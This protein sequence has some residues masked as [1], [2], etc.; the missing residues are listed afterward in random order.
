M[1]RVI[2]ISAS[3]IAVLLLSLA[4]GAALLFNT[5]P[6]RRFIVAQAEPRIS[7]AIGSDVTI[8]ALE[9]AP[10]SRLVLRNVQL[11]DPEG[12]WLT[13]ETVGLA[14]RPFRLIGGDIDVRRLNISGVKL[15]RQPLA[16]ETKQEE[17]EPVDLR[18]PDDLPHLTIGEITLDDFRSGLGGETVRL[19]GAGRLAMGDSMV[20][21]RLNLTSEND[22]DTVDIA[23]ELSP[24]AERLFVDATLAA[25]AGGVIDSFANLNGPLFINA[26]GDSPTDNAL[27]NINA[28]VADYGALE[29]T[30]SGD[31]A[32]INDIGLSALFTP[33]SALSGIDELSKPITIGTAFTQS[34]NNAILTLTDS[35]S[36][37][38][39]I[40][41]TIEWVNRRQSLTEIATDID[42]TFDGD[43]R[44]NI[45]D[46]SGSSLDAKISLRQLRDDYAFTASIA[47][48]GVEMMVSDGTTNLENL[49]TGVLQ[50][51]LTP[52]DGIA[53]LPYTTQVESRFRVD[54][55][56]AVEL[57][58]VSITLADGSSIGADAS[59]SF[60][61]ETV[62][63]T[64]DLEA[65]PSL[66]QSFVSSVEPANSIRA[67]FEASGPI[68][69]FAANAT[70]NTPAMAIS[71]GEAP[72]L[73]IKAAFAGLP[74]LPTGDL[75]A[76]AVDG[77]GQFDLSLRATNDG[78]I[79]IPSLQYTGAGFRLAGSGLVNLQTETVEI[80]ADYAGENDA[81]P[82]PGVMLVGDVSIDGDYSVKEA[83]SRFAVTADSL[84]SNDIAVSG[85]KIEGSGVPDRINVD[86]SAASLSIAQLGDIQT[87]SMTS[88]ADLND[89]T[90]ITLNELNGVLRS[91]S[92]NLQQPAAIR[93]EDGVAVEGFR[94]NWGKQG[95]IALDGALA[96]QQWRADLNLAD[97]NVPGA[98]SV[99]SLDLKLDTNEETPARGDFQLRSLLTTA[100]AASI[101][102]NLIWDREQLTLTSAGDSDVFD[103]RINLPAALTTQPS[104][105][106]ETSGALDGYARYEGPVGV[107]AAYLPPDLQTIEGALSADIT[108][109]GQTDDPKISGGAQ[110]SNGAYTEL[111]SGLSL[112]G[113]HVEAD[114]SYAS[115]GSIVSFSGGAR[116]AEQSTDDTITL[117]GEMNVDDEPDINLAL[118]LD[119]A[120]L[121]AFPVNTVRANGE[122]NVTGPLDA[123]AASGAVIIDELDAE[124]VTPENT[125]LVA[126]DVVAYDGETDAPRPTIEQPKTEIAYDL[127]VTADDRIFVRGRGLESEWA[128]DV[129]IV[130]A[131]DTALITGA[132]TLRRGW[133]DFSGR[134][135]D[136]TTGRITF[137]RLSANNPLLDIRAEYETSDGVTAVIAVS[138]RAETPSVELTSTPTLP[139][140]D[141]MALVLFGKPAGELT[142]LESLQTAQA[143]AS[144]GGI[145]PFGGAGGVTSSIREAVGLDL[146]NIDIDPENGGGSLTV[147]KYVADGFFVSAT[148]DAQGETGAVRVEYEITDNISVETE[149]QQDGD[150]TFSANWKRDF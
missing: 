131:K 71:D 115:T 97:V 127:S 11:A 120:A 45:Q 113:L 14:W 134:R 65:T 85:L 133:L 148:Q 37:V 96:A 128:A 78:T 2:V 89:Q 95:R 83:A 31:F 13:I 46:F 121:S 17:D 103:M 24:N 21:A 57:S 81:Q 101:N 110:L 112:A 130:N 139:S 73:T 53:L 7:E 34:R 70:I 44:T 61:D 76:R 93:L 3:A 80:D 142:A 114:A 79:N 6:G 82:W 36:A 4:L 66:V 67:A 8:G 25:E 48:E 122:I 74:E 86:A 138:G 135:F 111:Q 106:I 118:R 33:G 19:D 68:D 143:L 64:G 116:G 26:T 16:S 59:Y 52:Q 62:S 84:A 129:K 90:L 27:V 75:T 12:P 55:N 105:S 30:L 141:V 149:I 87:F 126:I 146:L 102:G 98:D 5:G 145:G 41:G 54:V 136:L 10:P 1:R 50:A 29:A 39:A 124:I 49:F 117:S 58:G 56:E 123:I 132:M 100:Q 108:L 92:F 140:E 51:T 38:G 107:I 47:G 99:I 43:Y 63:I 109:S 32:R 147:G 88:V 94:L 91:I 150:Q 72:P 28:V 18:L 15:L 22:K 104:V 144:L 60:S 119:D 35:S 40:S 77:E 42:V 9:G 69:R 137:D 125:G 23:L 20:H